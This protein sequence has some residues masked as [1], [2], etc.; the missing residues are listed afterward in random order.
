MT[1]SFPTAGDRKRKGD[2]RRLGFHGAG[3]QVRRPGTSSCC[4]R[5]APGELA[6]GLPDS[7]LPLPLCTRVSALGSQPPILAVE[8]WS[9]SIWATMLSFVWLLGT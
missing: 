2:G 4:P 8:P 1:D 3:V 5:Y 6:Y 9:L 7:H